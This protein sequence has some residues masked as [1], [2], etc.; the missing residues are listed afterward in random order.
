MSSEQ[1]YR[2]R[3]DDHGDHLCVELSG[4]GDSLETSMI[5]WRQIA[6][7]CERR[8]TRALLVLDRFG[9]EPLAPHEMDQVIHVMRDSYMQHVRVAYCKLNAAHLPQAEYGELHAREVGYNVRVFGDENE[10]Q[11]W[12]RYGE[13]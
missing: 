3:F 9:G 1:S 5:Y 7:E 11:L 12:L 13:D 10:A 8:G 6:D 4:P 2:L